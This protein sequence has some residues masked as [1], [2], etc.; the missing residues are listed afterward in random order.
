MMQKLFAVAAAVALAGSLACGKSAS[1][2]QAEQAAA[3]MQKAAEA[4]TKASETAGQ[5]VAKG[6]QDFAKAMSGMA[7]ALGAV[8][9]KTVEPVSFQ[10]LQTTLPEVSGWEMDKPRGERMTAPV[11]FAQTEAQYTKGGSR[12]EVKVVDSGSAPLLIAPW[13]MMLAA[14][15]SRETSEGYEKAITVNG[16]PAFEKW[17][18]DSKNGELNILVDKRFLVS[19]EG[20]DLADTKVLHEVAG[21]MDFGKFA[22]L[23]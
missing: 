16:Q 19:I 5:D 12:I 7:G 6:M 4:A 11:P 17:N 20:D 3:E 1:E 15:F 10:A 9:G 23:K 2:K 18:S 21:K 8:D 14:G 13:S 22:S